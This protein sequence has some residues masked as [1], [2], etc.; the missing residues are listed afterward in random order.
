MFFGT[1]E[2]TPQVAGDAMEWLANNPRHAL[3]SSR[4]VTLDLS[5]FTDQANQVRNGALRSGLPLAWVDE[6]QGIMKPD[7]NVVGEAAGILIDPVPINK[8]TDGA[9]LTTGNVHGNLMTRGA[10]YIN[11]LP[12]APSANFQSELGLIE[13]RQF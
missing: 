1:T 8:G 10:V 13:F 6:A 2:E 4:A 9:I 12:V 3:E 11:R 7:A 5:T